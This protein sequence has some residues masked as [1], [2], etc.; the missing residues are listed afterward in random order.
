MFYAIITL[1]E[2]Q[3]NTVV[4]SKTKKFQLIGNHFLNEIE[5][6]LLL[7][8]LGE[9]H[10]SASVFDLRFSVPKQNHDKSITN[11]SIN[12]KL[13]SIVNHWTEVK[14]TSHHHHRLQNDNNNDSSSEKTT[15]TPIVIDDDST[16]NEIDYKSTKKS[17]FQSSEILNTQ[18]ISILT[19]PPSHSSSTDSN[20]RTKSVSL[21]TP[22]PVLLSKNAQ[23]KKIVSSAFTPSPSS[24]ILKGIS[25]DNNNYNKN[26]KNISISSE[27]SLLTTSFF[28][29]DSNL[30]NS[31]ETKVDSPSKKKL[32]KI[33]I[34]EETP[35]KTTLTL[36]NTNE[37]KVI[38]TKNQGTSTNSIKNKQMITLSTS[39][40]MTLSKDEDLDETTTTTTTP[41]LSNDRESRTSL[42]GVN[43]FS[44]KS[45][46]VRTQIKRNSS[47][48]F[49]TPEWHQLQ[50]EKKL[51]TEKDVQDYKKRCYDDYLKTAG[52]SNE[53]A[54]A[55]LDKFNGNLRLAKE[56]CSNKTS[57]LAENYLSNKVKYEAD[58]K[59][60]LG[61]ANDDLNN[62]SGDNDDDDDE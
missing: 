19:T 33:V 48:L 42:S 16:S 6:L 49:G 47:I 10:P 44:P 22:S 57:K 53:I 35:T 32:A 61:L 39:K 34:I 8:I 7:K 14:N 55:V 62:E 29:L 24:S 52:V 41:M 59:I 13:E 31:D 51:A 9:N 43:M 15:T 4:Q 25:G 23:P 20:L 11:P 18:T 58:R 40:S 38:T 28:R 12:F 3:D 36:Q 60:Y 46:F 30:N 45:V 54:V 2:L 37:N 1:E 5:L 56:F 26:S 50:I 17:D 21:I 27:S